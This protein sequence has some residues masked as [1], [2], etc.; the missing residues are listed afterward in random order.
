ARQRGS[1][2]QFKHPTKKGTVT[3]NG[4]MSETQSQFMIN[5]ISKQAGWR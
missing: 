4:K 3:I 2:R 5:S 1:H